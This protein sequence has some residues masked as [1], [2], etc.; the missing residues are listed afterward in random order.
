MERREIVTDLSTVD[1]F[2]VDPVVWK[3]IVV[4]FAAIAFILIMS[5]I[6]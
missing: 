3:I 6:R 4:G 5:F 1:T 2:W